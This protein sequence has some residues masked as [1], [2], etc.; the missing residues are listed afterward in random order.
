MSKLSLSILFVFTIFFSCNDSDGQTAPNEEIVEDNEIPETTSNNFRDIT[1]MELVADMKPGWNVG[2]SLDAEGIDETVWGNPVITEELISAIKSRGFGTLR[3]P[4]TWRFHTGDAP[5]FIIEKA[6]L[7]R[8]E[9][10]VNYGL[11]NDMYVIL[12]IHHDEHWIIPTY[13]QADAVKDRLTKT[14]TQIAER[15]KDYSDYLIFE[16]LNEPRYE[17]QPQEWTGTPE[18]KDVVNQYHK[19][20]LDAIRATG[21]NN[22]LRHIMISSYAASQG[23]INDLIIPNNDERTIVSIHNYHPFN[24]ALTGSDTN[25][26]TEQDKTELDDIFDELYNKFIA[27]GKPVIMGEWASINRSNTEDRLAH[28]Q[29][30]A[31]GCLA[32]Q[33]LPV[34]WDNGNNDEYALI[35]R[36]TL[37]W[38]FP[39]IADAIINA[40]GN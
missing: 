23:A 12:N 16:T 39:Q 21:G 38:N 37:Q 5:N 10:V 22:L 9:E 4:V 6:W 20:S 36:N 18:W 27:N 13:A 2:N 19:T 26:G 3:V 40:T 29:Y 8:V 14:W 28:A 33:I 34:W 11:D 7:D 15:F 1:S 25:W 30:Y 24:F 32:K 31:N 35:N 17:G